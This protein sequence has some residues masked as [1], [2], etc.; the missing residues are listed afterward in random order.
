MKVFFLMRNKTWCFVLTLITCLQVVN[1]SINASDYSPTL[2][3]LTVNEIE[4]CVEFV[5][6][7]LLGCE[8]AIFEGPSDSENTGHRLTH[9]H[10]L[11]ILTRFEAPELKK[12]AIDLPKILTICNIK[13][14]SG[15][16]S[17]AYLPPKSNVATA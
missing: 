8:N 16:C 11:L 3:D 4:T 2:E 1:M 7:M 6:E 17:P 15:H 5:A 12:P 13:L 14:V 9:H 10:F